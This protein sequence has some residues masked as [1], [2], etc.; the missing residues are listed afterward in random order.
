LITLYHAPFARSVRVL[1]LLEELGVP[2]A[3][4]TLPPISATTPFSQDTPTG[5]I[6]TLEDGGL[7]MCE[8]IAILEY[9]LDR[10]GDGRLAPPRTSPAWGSFLQWLHY[11]EATAFPPLGYIARHSFALP[12]AERIPESAAE[13]RRLA[14]KVLAL[15]ERVLAA[16][17]YLVG[18]EFGAA[19]VAMGYTVGT[20]KLLGLLGEL[21]AL[22]AYFD[23]LAERPAF[24]RATS[25]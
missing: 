5:K 2:Y 8:S 19:D 9:V 3:L 15:P 1:W 18:G 23:R 22:S 25:V 10:Y 6:P 11:A 12:E 24:R 4:K 13:N 14:A 21:P 16:S 20:A 17:P 7:V